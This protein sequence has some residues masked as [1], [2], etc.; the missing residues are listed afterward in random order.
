MVRASGRPADELVRVGALDGIL[1]AGYTDL[2]KEVARA[3]AV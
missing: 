1:P 3:V 2:A